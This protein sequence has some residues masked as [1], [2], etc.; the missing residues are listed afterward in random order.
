MKYGSLVGASGCWCKH[1]TKIHCGSLQHDV[2]E[3]LPISMT[4]FAE[5]PENS[6]NI[7][8]ECIQVQFLG[9]S[10]RVSRVPS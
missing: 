6:L 10:V 1:T 4:Y 5:T 7:R 2:Q 9:E 8:D 3:I